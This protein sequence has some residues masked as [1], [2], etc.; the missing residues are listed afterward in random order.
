METYKPGDVV[1]LRS[2]G[3]K[4]TVKEVGHESVGLRSVWCEWFAGDNLEQKA[5]APE[6]LEKV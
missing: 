1:R 5:F 4:M 2:C 3:Q 6:C